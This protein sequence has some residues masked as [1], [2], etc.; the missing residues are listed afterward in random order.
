M[1]GNKRGYNTDVVEVYEDYYTRL[2][3]KLFSTKLDCITKMDQV[4]DADLR[5]SRFPGLILYMVSHGLSMLE[6]RC[7]GRRLQNSQGGLSIVNALRNFGSDKLFFLA[8]FE[9]PARRRDKSPTTSHSNSS[10]QSR[11]SSRSSSSSRS[12]SSSR[13]RSY[14]RSSSPASRHG[15]SSRERLSTHR[16]VHDGSQHVLSTTDQSPK[17]SAAS[18]NKH[19][20]TNNQS[21]DIVSEEERT[22]RFDR[23]LLSEQDNNRNSPRKCNAFSNTNVLSYLLLLVQSRSNSL[24]ITDITFT[25]NQPVRLESQPTVALHNNTNQVSGQKRQREE[26]SN[27]PNKESKTKKRKT[28]NFVVG[29]SRNVQPVTQEKQY[30]PPATTNVEPA[31]NQETSANDELLELLDSWQ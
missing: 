7:F 2:M 21:R 10:K 14:S 30:D 15:T 26:S 4:I 12:G 3:A 28:E 9:V 5:Y 27:E 24:V 6:Q 13:S 25:D 8:H 1:V 23:P 11:S 19:Q 17:R 29:I 31:T 16:R 18:L 20:P 22:N